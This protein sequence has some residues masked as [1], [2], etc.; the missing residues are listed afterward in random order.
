MLGSL[1][2]PK[3]LLCLN[4]HPQPPKSVW[5]GLRGQGPGAA[6]PPSL[7]LMEDSATA[8]LSV[9]S[10]PLALKCSPDPGPRGP[11]LAAQPPAHTVFG[12]F[13]LGHWPWSRLSRPLG[14]QGWAHPH[15]LGGNLTGQRIRLP[16]K[17]ARGG[18]GALEAARAGLVPPHFRYR[19]LP[20]QTGRL[21]S[22]IHSFTPHSSIKHLTLR[23]DRPPVTT[24]LH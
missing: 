19:P 23:P 16:E 18:E 10:W 22:S 4:L 24:Y 6:M 20:F 11:A 13:L 12:A 15:S 21:P 2:L 1:L 3:A 9:T 17:K 8:S 7:A 5:S 14:A